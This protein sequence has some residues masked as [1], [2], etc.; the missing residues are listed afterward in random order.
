MSTLRKSGIADL[1]ISGL[2][3]IR[4]SGSPEAGH[5]GFPK[6]LK[7]RISGNPHFLVFRTPEIPEVS[8]FRNSENPEFQNSRRD[9]KK[10]PIGAYNNLP[11]VQAICPDRHESSSPNILTEKLKHA[12]SSCEILHKED[13]EKDA[14]DQSANLGCRSVAAVLSAAA[15][16][17]AAASSASSSS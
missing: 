11:K 15:A 17:S 6:I 10:V 2:P 9:R 7:S 13:L 14:A 3:G 12:C 1:R 8:G 4:K 5:S 16:A